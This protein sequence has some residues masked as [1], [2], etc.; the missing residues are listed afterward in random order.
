VR[1]C[2]FWTVHDPSNPSVRDSTTN[3]LGALHERRLFIDPEGAPLTARAM[4]E[5]SHDAR[6]GK[7]RKDYDQLKDIPFDAF[8][9]CVRYMTW[10]LLPLYRRY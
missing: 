2:G 8:T 1:G 10:H 3:V 4:L 7:P 5:H 6:T 9:D